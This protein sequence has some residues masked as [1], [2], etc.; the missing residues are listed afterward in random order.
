FLSALAAAPPDDLALGFK[1]PPASAKPH[2][3]WHSMAGNVTKEG[4]TAD[5]EAMKQLGLGGAQM[6]T[7]SQ[8]IPPGPAGYMGPL[9]RE[10]TMHAVSEAARL[11][12]ELCIHN[13]AGW[14]SS[15]GPWVKP[16]NAMQVIGWSTATAHGPSLTYTIKL[17]PIKAPYVVS[18]VDYAKDIAVYA[19]RMNGAYKDPFSPNTKTRGPWLEKTGVVRGD[20][21]VPS[22]EPDEQPVVNADDIINVTDKVNADGDLHM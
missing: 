9:W 1:N 15:G 19:I 2:T 6:F 4:I 22:Y 20:N 13:C 8:G 18:K 17:P 3:R 10:M 16:E 14:S 7:V 21:I 12:L 11:G 5:L